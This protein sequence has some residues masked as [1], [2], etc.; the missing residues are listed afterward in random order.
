M[1][2]RSLVLI[3]T[4]LAAIG[5]ARPAAADPPD[6]A[7][8]GAIRALI[9]RGNL[10]QLEYP[11]FT[12]YRSDLNAFY[13]A[14]GYAPQWLDPDAPWRAALNEL[15]AA[16]THGLDPADYDVDWLRRE[17]EAIAAGDHASER[18]PRADVALTLSVFRLL[19][20]LHHGRVTP[21]SAGFHFKRNETP[22][23]LAAMLR[24]GIASRNL[25][26]AVAAAVPSFPL[27]TRLEEA[28]ARYRGFAAE[29]LPPIPPMPNRARKIEPGDT[30]RGV[31]A[32]AERLRRVGDLAEDAPLPPENRYDGA[33]VDAVR[34]FQERHGLKADGVLGRDTLAALAT[35]FAARVREL[36]LSLE[37]LRWLPEL[38]PG[39]VIAVNIPSFRLWAFAN[40]RRDSAS[41]LTMPV[42]V[43]GAVNA[44]K[45]PVFIGEMKYLEFSPYWNVTP[46]IQKNE[47][48]PKLRKDPDYWERED[49]EAV[50][51]GGKG[52]AI[53]ALDAST[54]DGL[55]RGTLRVRQRPGEKNALGRVKFVLPNT[56]DIYLHGTPAQRLFEKSRRDFSHGCIRVADPTAL[57]GFVL[58]DQPDWTSERIAEAMEAEKTSI[59]RLTRSIPVLIF[60]TTA[61]VDARNR[62]LFQADIYG[63]DAKLEKAL[64]ER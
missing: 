15:A 31:A 3:L 61:I 51:A 22:L 27:Y 6:Q 20:D 19:S 47:I 14:T 30:Y 4:F 24:E 12:A 54:L 11:D 5:G 26:E 48:V 37:R 13:R 10:S 63:Y 29:P 2:A 55:A 58:A 32:I 18:G 35:P 1:I 50:P 34:A 49:F 21:E 59:V 53:T 42:I 8:S 38:P 45:T 64:K 36:E 44:K 46:A 39:P 23:D 40:A 60:Y 9:A 43:G 28:L 57:A 16:S 62:V 17:F 7:V 25:H 33:I 52:G 41:S 56:M